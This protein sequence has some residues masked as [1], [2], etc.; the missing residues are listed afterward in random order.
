[1]IGKL[2][3]EILIG[4]RSGKAVPLD[5]EECKASARRQFEEGKREKRKL[6]LTRLKARGFTDEQIAELERRALEA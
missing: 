5:I 6:A 4:F 1:M 3:A 2:K